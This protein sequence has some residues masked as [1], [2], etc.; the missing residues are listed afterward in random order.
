MEVSTKYFFLRHE[1]VFAVTVGLKHMLTGSVFRFVNEENREYSLG[2]I[3]A[4]T[5]GRTL[6]LTDGSRSNV[7][8]NCNEFEAS[9]DTKLAYVSILRVS[10]GNIKPTD[11]G[12]RFVRTISPGREWLCVRYLSITVNEWMEEVE[13]A[14]STSGLEQLDSSM[15]EEDSALLNDGV[16]TGE[17]DE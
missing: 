6:A 5:F 8:I 13:Q 9:G 12:Y 7:Y 4:I 17:D 14:W 15:D 3:N 2:T 11:I 16:G 1:I 10:N